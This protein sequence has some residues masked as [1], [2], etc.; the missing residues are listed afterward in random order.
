MTYITY[1]ASILA[2]YGLGIER[3]VH[4]PNVGGQ[5]VW[6]LVHASIKFSPSLNILCHI[7]VGK[8]Q[9]FQC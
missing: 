3:E 1:I 2:E 8:I 7:N 6:M 4:Q 9:L 5:H